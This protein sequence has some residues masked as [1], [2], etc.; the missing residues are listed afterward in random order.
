MFISLKNELECQLYCLDCDCR[1]D[2]G[3]YKDGNFMFHHN[4]LDVP[5][6]F[7]KHTTH[8]LG[9][10]TDVKDS[11]TGKEITLT[12]YRNCWAYLD[13]FNLLRKINPDFLDNFSL[14]DQSLE[15]KKIL[16]ILAKPLYRIGGVESIE[17]FQRVN[18]EKIN[19]ENENRKDFISV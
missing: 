4:D 15:S 7:T 8:R 14:G 13:S 11:A 12:L 10:L 2:G 17:N 16:D 5:R 9:I 6:H 18:V 1:L 3:I 19:E